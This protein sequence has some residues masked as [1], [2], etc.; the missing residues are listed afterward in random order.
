MS[1]KVLIICVWLITLPSVSNAEDWFYL[2]NIQDHIKV[3]YSMG[4]DE[5]TGKNFMGYQSEYG[6]AWVVL[7][8][9]ISN[10][11][12]TTEMHIV[13]RMATSEECKRYNLKKGE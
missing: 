13:Y 9:Y 10:E 2:E 6:I 5:V 1:I 7:D 8:K 3:L 12:L 4:Y 11:T